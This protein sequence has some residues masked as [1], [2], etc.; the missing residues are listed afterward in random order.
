TRADVII[1]ATGYRI[2][3]PFLDDDVFTS[4][5]NK[6]KLYKQVVPVDS[7]GLFF[8]GLIQPV[9]ALPPL[10]EQ[11][12]RWVSQLLEGASLPSTGE[13]R[14]DIVTDTFERTERYQDRPRHTIQ[15]D[16]WPYLDSMRAIC[17]ANEATSPG[18][19]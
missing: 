15:V 18:G 16:Y 5:D 13:M 1:Y 19:D 7:P 10:A 11:Q 2:S 14:A 3:F 8:V 6:V 9:G 17:D 4:D 12:A